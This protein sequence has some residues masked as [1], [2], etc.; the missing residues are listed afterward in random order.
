MYRARRAAA[1]ASIAGALACSAAFADGEITI[2]PGDCVNGVHLS[3]RQAPLQSVLQALAKALDFEL[4]YEGDPA[5]VISINATRPPVDLV[6]ALSPQDSIVVTQAPDPRCK[7]RHRIVKVW[8]LASGK[9]T[10]PGTSQSAKTTRP[11][12]TPE[13]PVKV[14]VNET[15]LPPSDALEEQSRRAKEAYD[16]YVRAHGKPPD[17]IQQEEVK[18]DK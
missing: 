9:A 6:S 13:R 17:G 14:G 3:A 16:A 15:V 5:R 10:T 2:T 7:A 18:N 4:K 12:S 8:V 1:F 11:A